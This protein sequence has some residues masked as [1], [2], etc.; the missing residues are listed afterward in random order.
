MYG[1]ESWRRSF[2]KIKDVSKQNPTHDGVRRLGP[3]LAGGATFR[4][5]CQRSSS[6]C[7]ARPLKGNSSFT[8]RCKGRSYSQR[9]K[10]IPTAPPISSCQMVRFERNIWSSYKRLSGK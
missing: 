4:R 5:R 1:S 7:P 2:R 6:D 9:G 10:A 8:A 3:Q